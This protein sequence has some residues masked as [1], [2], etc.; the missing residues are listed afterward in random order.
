M[1]ELLAG[2]RV[3]ESA[4]LFNGDT[5]GCLLG[6]LGADVI[7]VES[8]FQGDY[9]RWML[10]QMQPGHSPA[11][12][13]IN[14]NKRSV[15]IDLRRDEGREVLWRLL[16]TADV[17]IDGN[18]G[19]ALD[20]LG[21]GYEAQ[22]TRKPDI[23][24]CQY[25]G[26]GSS[27]PY[28]S[29][30]THGQMMDALAGAYPREMGEDGFLHAGHHA[31]PLSGMDSGG[32]GT[33]AGAVHAALHIAASV[34]QKYRTGEGAY[35]DVAGTDGVIKQAWISAT[36]TLNDHRIVDRRSMPAMTEGRMTGATYQYY[37]C[38]DGQNILFCCIE[39]KFWR[40]FC[41]AIDRDDLIDVNK[42]GS[43][44]GQS[45]V[46]FG[47][48]ADDLRHELQ[49]IFHTRDLAEWMNI[50]AEYDVAMGPAY[51]SVL[52]AADD[53]QV[54]SRGVIHVDAHPGIGDFTYVGEAGVVTRQPFKVNRPAPDLGEHTREILGELSYTEDEIE[55]LAKD[56]VI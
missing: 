37:E 41:R 9:L 17:F 30:P 43:A 21:V 29:V 18:A 22:R 48:D 39:P 45:P 49:G 42:G 12:V 19:D 23:I 54:R 26:Y 40:N 10:G 16:E 4:V 46:D 53:P 32:E 25:S 55:A 7:K 28:A 34:A 20:R 8:P 6:D 44:E 2:T 50:A 11:H 27:G 31:G 35:I 51:R 33:S 38:K 47:R 56:R 15:T 1:S 36:Y 52:E 14:R 13:Q 3:L 24:Y 5:V